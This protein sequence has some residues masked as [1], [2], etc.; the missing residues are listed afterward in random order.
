MDYIERYIGFGTGH[1]EEPIA[2]VSLKSQA[3]LELLE[4]ATAFLRPKQSFVA[5]FMLDGTRVKDLAEVSL[6]CK[7]LLFSTSTVF[8]GIQENL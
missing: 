1:N 6:T 5:V 4:T 3:L 2:V 7:V 8:H